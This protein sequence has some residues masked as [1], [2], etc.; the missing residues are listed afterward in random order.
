MSEVPDRVNFYSTLHTKL[1]PWRIAKLYKARGWEVRKC[2]W[3]DYEASCPWAELVIEAASPVL[4]NGAVADI[5][6]NA[7][8]LLAPLK[9]ANVTFLAE[10]YGPD[11]QLLRE[12]CNGDAPA[13]YRR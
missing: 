6:A 2:A 4:M 11:R 1:S 5:L 10:G 3:Y 7:D 8:A 12:W 9:A 13:T